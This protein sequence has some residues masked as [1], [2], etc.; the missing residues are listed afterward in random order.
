MIRKE[1]KRKNKTK[2]ATNFISFVATKMRGKLRPKD[3]IEK[4]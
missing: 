2:N 4:V 3:G 1:M